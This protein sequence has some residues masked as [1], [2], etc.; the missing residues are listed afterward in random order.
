MNVSLF[1][2]DLHRI[3]DQSNFLQSLNL[4]QWMP[5]YV[6]LFVIYFKLKIPKIPGRLLIQ[7]HT[8][9]SL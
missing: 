4:E 6:N 5:L 9:I 8:Y 3:L 2:Q 1:L 7:V